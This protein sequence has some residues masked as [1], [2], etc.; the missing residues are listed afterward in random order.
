MFLQLPPNIAS[1]KLHLPNKWFD[2]FEH[3]EDS[4][5]APL[6]LPQS[7]LERLTSFTLFC[8]WDG[9]QWLEDAPGQCVNLETLNMDFMGAF[10][11]CN[12]DQH[13]TERLLASGLLLP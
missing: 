4:D 13:D 9:T 2:A 11:L 10:W 5:G 8:D 12:R 6:P 1:F 7:L 3:G